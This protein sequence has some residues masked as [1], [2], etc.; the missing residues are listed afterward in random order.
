M[1][2]IRRNWPSECKSE[3]LRIEIWHSGEACGTRCC[4]DAGC[5]G[6][7]TAKRATWPCPRGC[8][9]TPSRPRAARAEA[10]SQWPERKGRCATAATFQRVR[11]HCVCVCVRVCVCACVRVCVWVWSLRTE[12]TAASFSLHYRH[13]LPLQQSGVPA[14]AAGIIAA[15]SGTVQLRDGVSAT[16]ARPMGPSNLIFVYWFAPRMNIRLQPASQVVITLVSTKCMHETDGVHQLY[17]HRHFDCDDSY[18]PIRAC[19]LHLFAVNLG[20]SA[21]CLEIV[22]PISTIRH[23]ARLFGT[24]A[25]YSA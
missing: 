5:D 13:G 6:N 18:R 21:H 3:L 9:V 24:I 7:L 22:H 25:P 20:A 16:A 1:L 23:S 17:K 4:D 11:V 10:H 12:E 19:I 8:D 2:N 15:F 14:A